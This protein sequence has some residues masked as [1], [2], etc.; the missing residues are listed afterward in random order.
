VIELYSAEN[1]NNER[2][3]IRSFSKGYRNSRIFVKGGEF[4]IPKGD[5]IF[6]NYSKKIVVKS[7]YIDKYEVSYNDIINVYPEIVPDYLD[8]DELGKAVYTISYKKAEK[9]CKLKGGDLPTE[10]QWIVAAAFDENGTFHKYPAEIDGVDFIDDVVDVKYSIKG[11]RGIYGMLG[12]VWELIKS[13]GETI[14]IKGGSFF[15]YDKLPLLDV[16]V[17][18]FVLKKEVAS[19]LTIGFRCVYKGQE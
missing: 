2:K 19:R 15:D 7:F 18:N 5:T 9:F 11:N 14:L 16:R 6:T 17:K 12:N 3:S 1:L 13:G 8:D 10:N 4:I